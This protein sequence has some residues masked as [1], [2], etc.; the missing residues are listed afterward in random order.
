MLTR[1]IYKGIVITALLLLSICETYAQTIDGSTSVNAEETYYY[2]IS[3][4]L[5]SGAVWHAYYGDVISS[6]SNGAS[7]KWRCGM[8][9]GTV[10]VTTSTNQ[11]ITYKDVT[12]N[13]NPTFSP[14]SITATA[15]Y[16]NYNGGTTITGSNATGGTCNGGDYYYQWETSSDGQNFSVISGATA[17]NYSMGALTAS[18]TYYRRGAKR[19]TSSSYQ[20]SNVV[21]VH[22]YPQ[23]VA[24][25]IGSSQNINY[26]A[27]PNTLTAPAATGG[28]GSY[29]YQWQVSSNPDPVYFNDISGANGLSYSPGNLTSTTYYM[30]KVSSNG[31]FAYSN[32]VTVTVYNLLAIG[33]ITPSAVSIAYNGSPGTL[34]AGTPTGGNGTYAYQWWSSTDNSTFTSIGSAGQNSSYTPTGLTQTMYYKVEL[35]SNGVS[36]FSNIATVTVLVATGV[37]APSNVT[38]DVNSNMNWLK[39]TIYNASGNV[40]SSGKKFYDYSGQMLQT[41]N[42]VFYRLNDN[43]VYTHVFASQPMNDQLGRMAVSTLSAPIDCAEFNYKP[44]FVQ[45]SD[46]SSYSYK[47]FESGPVSVQATWTLNQPNTSGTYQA[48]QTITLDEGFTSSTTADFIAEIVTSNGS[49]VDK[50]NSPDKLGNQN[51]KGTLGWYYSINNTWEPYTP[52]TDNPYSRQTFYADGTG[53]VKKSAVAGNPLRMGNGHEVSAYITPVINELDDYLRIRNKYF[54]GSDIGALPATMQKLAIQQIAHDENGR[55]AIAIQDKG[56]K[57]LFTARPGTD[58]LVNNSLTVD[59]NG[60]HYFKLF[61][62]GIVTVTGGS[63]SIINMDNE[64]PVSFSSGSNLPAGYYKLTNTGSTAVTLAYSNGYTDVSYSFYNQLGQL[65]ATIAPE[66]V[67][68]LYNAGINSYVTKND[69]PFVD[70][71]EYDTK[72]RLVKNTTPDGGTTDMVYRKDGK[73]RFSKN[74]S[75]SNIQYKYLNYDQYGRQVEAGVYYDQGGNA[76]QFNSDLSANSSMKQILENNTQR[77]GFETISSSGNKLEVTTVLYDKV[78]TGHGLTAYGYE[79]D[80]A[81]LGGRISMTV[82][83][84]TVSVLTTM[85]SDDIYTSATPVCRTWYNYDEEGKV[86]WKIQSTQGFG[87]KTTDYTYDAEGRLIKKVYQKDFPSDRFVHYYEYDAGT[88]K[89]RKVYTHI[90]DDPSTKKLQ[91]TYLY[92]LHGPL[93]RIELADKLQGIDYTYTLNGALKSINNS[94]K[95]T[96]PGADGS[97]GVPEDAFGMVLDYYANDYVNERLGIEHIRG[98]STPGITDSYVGNIKAMTWFSKKP[99]SQQSIPGIE[100]RISYVYQYDDKY[101][102]TESTWGNNVTDAIPAGYNTTT[103]NKETVKDPANGASAYDANGNVKYLQRTDGTGALAKKFVYNYVN[104]TNKLQSVVNEAGGSAVTYGTYDYDLVGRLTK[105]EYIQE[106]NKNK[107]ISYNPAGLL[108]AVYRDV[109]HSQRVV[110]YEY[111]EN[112]RRIQKRNYNSSNNLIQVTYYVGGVV[113]TQPVTQNAGVDVYGSITAQEYEIQGATGNLGIYY[114][115]VDVYAYQLTDHLGNVRSVIAKSGSSYEVRVYSDYYPYGKVI[116]ADGDYRYG[117]QGQYAEKDPETDWNAFEL[118]MYDSEI[119]K[120]LQYD[121]AGQFWSPYVAMGNDPVKNVDPRGDKIRLEGNFWQKSKMVLS[122]AFAY[123]FSSSARSMISDLMVSPNVHTIK[124]IRSGGGIKDGKYVNNNRTASLSM[125]EDDSPEGYKTEVEDEVGNIITHIGTGKGA[126]SIV[127]WDLDAWHSDKDLKGNIWR[128][129]YIGLLHELWH[130]TQ[131]DK[132]LSI[133]MEMVDVVPYNEFEAVQ[134]ENIFRVQL[135]FLGIFGISPRKEYGGVD[136][137]TPKSK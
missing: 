110:S 54:S 92:Y 98:V 62:P 51:V 7:V 25:A 4:S 50:T 83:Y 28:N 124:T 27:A 128:P 109:N 131:I 85:G 94:K 36:A 97:N 64:Q 13:Q 134:Y 96:D 126:G 90:I 55:E 76:V 22:A 24:G 74:A 20:Y 133:R 57:K 63:F 102:F 23:L 8:S 106:P 10:Y 135:G 136:V 11:T 137:Y 113:Y 26:N 78:N 49:I 43:T 114:K 81:T 47:N 111:D 40:V 73:L 72:G 125:G 82:K 61:V 58:L 101:Q 12:I 71:Y 108:T 75:E 77:G 44:D 53:N 37:A 30:L 99:A 15:Q 67:K 91:A 19:G 65:V 68:K 93:K 39:T 118:R 17:L 3:G 18:V 89:L 14:G 46:G 41:Q 5:P 116:R 119:A 129:R 56:G 60:I 80:E 59:A 45:A 79:Q 100:D 112:G 9:T 29:S 117:Y 86:I 35:K 88:Q 66:G 103:F 121:P 16:V 130:A 132:G 32:I 122:L 2:S 42:K 33:N 52:T 1:K 87:A 31:V 70:L 105:E 115:P 127:E 104:N 69:I 123:Y 84:G 48:S 6:S 21:D 38:G 95:L 107:F 34:T 120:W